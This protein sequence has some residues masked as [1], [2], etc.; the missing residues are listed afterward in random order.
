MLRHQVQSDGQIRPGDNWQQG[1]PMNDYMD[2]MWRHF[3][4]V[5]E[6]HRDL[7]VAINQEEALCALLFNVMGYLHECLK[8]KGA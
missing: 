5:W 4:D 8:R 7:G 3:M 2:S 6:A 1:I